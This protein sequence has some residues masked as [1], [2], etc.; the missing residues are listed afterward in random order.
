MQFI[1]KTIYFIK[2]KDERKLHPSYYTSELITALKNLE[3]S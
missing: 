1:F 3:I 2:R